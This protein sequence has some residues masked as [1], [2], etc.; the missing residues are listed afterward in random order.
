M[1]TYSKMDSMCNC[2][3]CNCFVCMFIVFAGCSIELMSALISC[4]N[5]LVIQIEADVYCMLRKVINLVSFSFDQ[6]AV[7]YCIK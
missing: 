7:F 3:T 6:V 2:S 5:L 1:L 4:S